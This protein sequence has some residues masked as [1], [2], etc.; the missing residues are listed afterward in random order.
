MEAMMEMNGMIVLDF[1][2]VFKMVWKVLSI[3]IQG[4]S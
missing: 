2:K 4:Q 3:S 1:E